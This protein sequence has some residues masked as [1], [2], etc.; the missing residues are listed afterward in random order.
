MYIDDKKECVTRKPGLN[1]SVGK[2]RV[3][4]LPPNLASHS[5][6]ASV[7][8][9]H[10]NRFSGTGS[11]PIIDFTEWADNFRGQR[12]N[13]VQEFASDTP[14]FG[15]YSMFP[16]KYDKSPGKWRIEY[17]M[18]VDAFRSLMNSRGN[19]LRDILNTEEIAVLHQQDQDR[20]LRRVEMGSKDVVL[21]IP[22][23]DG[24][25][26]TWSFRARLIKF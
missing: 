3:V 21:T 15:L 17:P 23:I 14:R 13:V 11:P 26:D 24:V 10:T 4:S 2:P 6:H 1:R 22:N 16:E 9:N 18:L 7:Y 12:F 25:V 20:Q 8:N 5:A 19:G